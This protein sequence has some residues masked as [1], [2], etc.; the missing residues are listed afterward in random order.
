VLL[1]Y[2]KSLLAPPPRSQPIDLQGHIVEEEL[3]PEHLISFKNL[4]DES[5]GR[6][7]EDTI[8]GLVPSGEEKRKKYMF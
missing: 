7:L 1:A 2:I 5:L 4:V 3:A 6:G 8:L